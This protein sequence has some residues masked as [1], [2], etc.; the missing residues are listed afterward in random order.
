MFTI[1]RAKVD[2]ADTLLKLARMVHFINLPP[3]KEIIVQKVIHSRN[4]FLKLINA[5]AKFEP[6]PEP[7]AIPTIPSTAGMSGLGSSTVKSPLFMFVLEDTDSGG[8]L[9]TSQSLASMGGPGN[10][11]VSFKLEE[12]NFFSKSLQTGTTQIVA[13][14]HLDESSPTEIGGLILQPS[15]RGHKKKLG[16]FLSLIRFHFMGLHR[17][18]FSDRVLAEMMAPITADGD[19]LLWDY[20]GRRFVPLSYDEA[21]R[22]CQ[23]SR[24]FITSLL[25][26]EPLYLSLLPPQA[27]AVVGEVGPETR[28]ARRMLER[29][30]FEYDNYV[31]PFDGGPH[32]SAATDEIAPVKETQRLELGKPLGEERLV[33][34]GIMSFQQSDGDFFAI[35]EPF[36]IDRAGRL[37][38]THEA[39][40]HLH[41][42]P[43]DEIGVTPTDGEGPAVD[44]VA[45]RQVKKARTNGVAG[46]IS[47]ATKKTTKKRAKT[48]S[49]KATRKV[50]A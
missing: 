30:G 36:L 42:R 3:D 22:F 4:S 25:P 1:R 8:V 32:L 18:S 40:E 47:K 10:P 43:G 34:H 6:E 41:A 48:A 24:E 13:T 7:R 26:N 37:C 15:Y 38:V 45:S 16:R 46:K 23:Y 2:D 27:R 14:M 11:N 31:D 44:A 17:N 21:D 33:R 20:L 19:N 28:P 12:R 39:M 5:K 50:R 49:K 29:L 35:H 9:G